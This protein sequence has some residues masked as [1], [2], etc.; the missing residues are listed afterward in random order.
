MENFP[1]FSFV[2]NLLPTG[3]S[4]GSIRKR[5]EAA[6]PSVIKLFSFFREKGRPSFH[7][8]HLKPLLPSHGR[9]L[10]S[11]FYREKRVEL[12]L[13]RHRKSSHVLNF[14]RFAHPRY[15]NR[16]KKAEKTSRT[17]MHVYPFWAHAQ[18]CCWSL[19]L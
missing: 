19:S 10:L 18:C 3:F 4:I 8:L 17:K 16:I 15:K 9:I 13:G 14:D 2:F 1:L 5:E 7:S 6:P 12:V 11:N